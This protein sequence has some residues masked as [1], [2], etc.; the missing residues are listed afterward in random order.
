[1]DGVLFEEWLREM[2]RKFV[3]ERRKVALVTYNCP[4]CL[5]I[6]NSKSIKLFFFKPI[7]TSQTQPM[8]QGVIYSLKT[9]YRKNDVRKII[10]S[11][12]KKKLSQK[13]LCY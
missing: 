4:A 11:V 6:E 13:C 7:T 1:M 5:Q 3:S 12:E 2:D 8:D 9:Q 10:R